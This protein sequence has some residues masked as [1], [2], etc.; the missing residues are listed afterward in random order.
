MLQIFPNREKS[1]CRTSLMLVWSY[2]QIFC[3]F[4]SLALDLMLS[5]RHQKIIPW[6][7][8]FIQNEN[9]EKN[10]IVLV[11]ASSFGQKSC[12]FMT[13]W[14]TTWETEKKEADNSTVKGSFYSESAMRLSNLQHNYSKSLSWAW[15]LNKLFTV[16]G[17]KFKFQGQDSDLEYFFGNLTNPSHFLKKS[18]F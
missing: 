5:S 3:F 2:A 7:L 12:H 16:F 15:N 18:H 1:V 17:G 14:M 8:F 10:D 9:W 6:Q 11:K 4:F 13:F